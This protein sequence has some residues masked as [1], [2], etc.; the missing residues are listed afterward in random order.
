M[1]HSATWSSVGRCPGDR[2]SPEDVGRRDA[3]LTGA[4]AHKHETLLGLSRGSQR[5]RALDLSVSAEAL[6]PQD[7]AHDNESAAD[8]VGP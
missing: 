1:G 8:L 7:G 4:G 6:H 2:S 3:K 5:N